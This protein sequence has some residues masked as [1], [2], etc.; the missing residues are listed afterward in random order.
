VRDDLRQ[1][2]RADT[3]NRVEFSQRAE[4]LAVGASFDDGFGDPRADARE[5]RE[6][7]LGGAIDVDLLVGTEG[8]ACGSGA[9][10]MSGEVRRLRAGHE[11]NS[12][13]RRIRANGEQSDS[14]PDEADSDQ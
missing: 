9:G 14:V 6:V 1:H 2:L 8:S 4:A 10:S 11:G 5:A 7:G 13:G 3:R 12:P